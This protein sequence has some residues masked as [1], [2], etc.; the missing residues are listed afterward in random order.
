[1]IDLHRLHILVTVAQE[2][3]LTG[4]AE[5]LGLG[6]PTVTHHLQRL[7]AD[8]GA[9]L[10]TRSGRRVILTAEGRH[11]VAEGEKILGTVERTERTLRAMTNLETGTVRLAAF[12]SAVP[13]LVPGILSAVGRRAPGL[14]IELVEAE[15][16]EAVHLLGTGSAD[17]A[18]IF[19]YPEGS[20]DAV[21]TWPLAD[22]PL[23]L[24]EPAS[25][26]QRGGSVT[27]DDLLPHAERPW[28]TGCARCRR[29]LL[30]ACD[31]AGF[32]PTITFASDDYVSVQALVAAGH[33]VTML[34][35]LALRA[36][37]HPGVRTRLVAGQ[38][39]T[40]MIATA[41]PPPHSPAV[42]AVLQAA[43]E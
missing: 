14:R 43:L 26:S 8:V 5:V 35:E 22:D 27:T 3:T 42:A 29:H 20:D 19:S 7:Q 36:Y 9:A 10:L 13:T 32:S 11:L 24:V 17:V 41:G 38:S 23:L 34:P 37:T 31:E 40:L 15:P 16:P 4:A 39:R 28:I 1:M 6:Q 30:A 2:G 12:P 25:Q 33:G 18:L 21:T